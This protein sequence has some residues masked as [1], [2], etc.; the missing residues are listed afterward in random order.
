VRDFKFGF[1]IGSPRSAAELIEACRTA[2]AYG[3]D[4][5]TAVDH[6]GP[7]RLAP[8]QALLA[9]ANATERLRVGT[10]VVNVGFWNAAMLAREVV[11][12]V[13][14]TNGRL[15]L[16]LGIGLIKAEFDAAG[17]PFLPFEARRAAVE[18]AIEEI[19]ALIAAEGGI[20]RPPLLIGGTGERVLR[21]AAERADI[22]SFAGLH[23]I[24][25]RPPGTFRLSTAEQTDRQ[26]AFVRSV[27]G[28]RAGALELNNF[29][30]IVEITDDRRAAAERLAAEDDDD[31]LVIDDPDEAL[32][33][34]YL[35]LG[36]EEQIAQQILDDCERYG[37][38][39]ITVQRPHME[40]LGPVIKRVHSLAPPPIRPLVDSWTI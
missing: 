24:P 1:T 33:T 5:A 14:L 2:E 34:P 28:D 11:T 13:R 23:Q 6:L 27:A 18:A 32:R 17:I 15:D 37:F 20:Q 39:A 40:L 10:Y 30:K 22:V 9:A 29:V 4:M 12:A 38:T 26:V 36:T 31:Y 21:L 3:Y 16:G 7:G 8:F 35:L 19:D 25:G